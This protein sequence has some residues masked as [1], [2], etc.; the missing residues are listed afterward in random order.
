MWIS[1]YLQ[2]W[3][4]T[5]QHIILPGASLCIGTFKSGSGCAVFPEFYSY[6]S[7]LVTTIAARQELSPFK[8]NEVHRPFSFLLTPQI[9]VFGIH[10]WEIDMFNQ[11]CGK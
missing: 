2:S 11:V 10:V 3:Q 8:V 7:L 5:S 9:G 6:E 4:I 1:E